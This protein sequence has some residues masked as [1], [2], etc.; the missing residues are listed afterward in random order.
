M[1][2][3]TVTWHVRMFGVWGVA[4]DDQKTTQLKRLGNSIIEKEFRPLY[5][6]YRSLPTEKRQLTTFETHNHVYL[7]SLTKQGDG[8]VPLF[9]NIFSLIVRTDTTSR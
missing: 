2:M 8:R 3:L 4:I 6:M 1:A 9:W 5:G 7:G